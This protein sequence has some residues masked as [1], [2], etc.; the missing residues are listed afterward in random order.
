M[1][2]RIYTK[3]RMIKNIDLEITP[4]ECLHIQRALRLLI[5]NEDVNAID[6]VDCADMLKKMIEEKEVIEI[7]DLS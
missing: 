4:V 7:G 2:M 5:E 3:E 1:K 6:R